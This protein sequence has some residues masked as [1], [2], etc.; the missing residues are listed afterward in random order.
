MLAAF[1]ET[2]SACA[3][4]L[5]GFPAKLSSHADEHVSTVKVLFLAL[6]A[7]QPVKISCKTSKCIWSESNVPLGWRSAT[8]NRSE[9]F[10]VERG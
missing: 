3:L 5:H 8:V 6:R 9:L 2:A 4:C 10:W 7:E 1:L